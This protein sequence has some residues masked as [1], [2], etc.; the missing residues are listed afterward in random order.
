MTTA[1]RQVLDAFEALPA[2]ERHEASVE[3]L[4]RASPEGDIPEAGLDEL[5]EDLFRA[6]DA[7]V[8]SHAAK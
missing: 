1:V 2:N 3:I 5:A 8:E 7:E 4:R 6:L